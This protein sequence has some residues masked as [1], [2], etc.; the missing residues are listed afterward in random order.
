M[1]SAKKYSL[2][3][4]VLAA[5]VVIHFVILVKLCLILKFTGSN[6]LLFVVKSI[7]SLQFV[8]Q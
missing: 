4:M 1:L 6:L 7:K 5:R 8:G 2:L 3:G